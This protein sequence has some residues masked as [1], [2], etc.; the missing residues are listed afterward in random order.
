MLLTIIL[1]ALFLFLPAGFANSIP[2]I[3]NK[4]QW[5]T[6]LAI[7]VDGKRKWKGE[8]IFG[9][10]KT[11]RGI[12]LGAIGGIFIAALQIL[13]YK[14]FIQSHWIFLFPY[15]SW[16]LLL[17]GFLMGLGALLGDLIKSFFKR[18]RSIASGAPFFPFDQLDLVIGSL[19]LG[20]LFYIPPWQHIL[21]LFL[22]IPIFSILEN[23]IAYKLGWK[24]V[25]Y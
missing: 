13:L 18:R 16:N 7:P 1:Q 22:T 15:D 11:W 25:W 20:A 14:F 8:F 24:E 9:S 10:H 12:F 5:L 2:I 6:F 23:A 3:F 21:T 19:L 17:W 4:F